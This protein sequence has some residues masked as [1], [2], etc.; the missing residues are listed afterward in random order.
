MLP[1]CNF[2]QCY[3]HIG[4]MMKE[5]ITDEDVQKALDYL[6]LNA[7]RAAQARANK[8]YME[9][10]RKTVKAQLMTV[11]SALPV[12]AQEREAYRSKA[13]TDHLTALKDAVYQDELNRWGM[14]AA[15]STI[16]AWRTQNAN[17]RG[18]GKLQ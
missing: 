13:Y 8:V 6:R 16:E 15:T 3:L 2:L 1:L 17:R 4:E 10:F 18:E 7:P 12:N 9:E 14:V 5:I 11:Y